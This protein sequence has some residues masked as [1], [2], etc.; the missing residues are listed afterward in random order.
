[1]SELDD[2]EQRARDIAARADRIAGEAKDDAELRE[3]LERLDLELRQLE[4]ELRHLDD[5]FGSPRA[6][7]AH[8][9]RQQ[10]SRPSWMDTLS[11]LLSGVAEQVAA[12]GGADW[13]WRASGTITRTVPVD[14][15]RSV[16]IENR[17]GAVQ[18]LAGEDHEVSVSA[19]RLAWNPALLDEMRVTAEDDGSQV[20]VRCDWTGP[21]KGRSARLNVAVPVGS[22]V[23]AT[24]AG[25]SVSTRATQGPAVL[26]TSGGSIT[27]YDTSGRI[28]ARTAGGGIRIENHTGAVSAT[29]MGGSVSVSG[30]LAGHVEARTAGGSIDIN[31]ADRASVQASTSGGSIRVTGRLV[32][33]NRLRTAGGSISVG[34]PPDSQLRVDGKGTNAVCDFPELQSVRG[35]IEGTIGDGSDGEIEVRTAGGTVS[36]TKV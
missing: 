12:F 9:P 18:I 3:E 36:L 34:I 29:T 4:D 35:R 5:E 2:L 26:R 19:E 7:H 23:S 14:G 13:G 33:Q 30:K 27:A 1:M 20:I 10:T 11:G 8:E 17:T 24:T 22:S 21:S 31:G 6:D 15:P 28:E 16:V 25:G 32:G